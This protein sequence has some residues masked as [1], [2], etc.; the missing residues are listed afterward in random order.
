MMGFVASTVMATRRLL[1][2][3]LVALVLISACTS[4]DGLSDSDHVPVGRPESVTT[5]EFDSATGAGVD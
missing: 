4:N 5:E 1:L 3:M 2:G